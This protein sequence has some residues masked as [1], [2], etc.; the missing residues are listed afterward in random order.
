MEMVAPMLECR[1]GEKDVLGSIPLGG[2][3][4]EILFGSFLSNNTNGAAGHLTGIT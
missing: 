1:A 2:S 3:K 4:G